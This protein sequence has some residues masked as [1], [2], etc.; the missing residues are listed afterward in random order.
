MKDAV[1]IL[2]DHYLKNPDWQEKV[3][4]AY[5]DMLI[6]QAIY[7][8]RT[9][10]GMTQRELADLVGTSYSCISRLED[11]DYEGHT[12]SM[13]RRIARALG[14]VIFIRFVDTKGE[15]DEA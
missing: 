12:M 6:G 14:K 3:D 4:R 9:E 7:D 10:A 2:R 1:E 15:T 5:T 11:A 13:L 8:L